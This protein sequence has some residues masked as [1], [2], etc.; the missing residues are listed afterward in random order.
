MN[1]SAPGHPNYQLLFSLFVYEKEGNALGVL[2]GKQGA[3]HQP[4]GYYTQQADPVAQGYPPSLKAIPPT[5]L[6][7]KAT[8]ETAVGSP[9]TIF[10]SHA[11]EAPLNSH[12]THLS[13]SHLTSYEIL[14]LYNSLSHF[15]NLNPATLLPS[16]TDKK[17]HNHLTLTDRLLT[18][19]PMTYKKVES[20]AGISWFTHGSY[21]RKILH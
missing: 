9:V 15:N 18:P 10:M 17:P 5:A 11:V 4:T 1:T 2:T 20:N 3:Y 7:A 21:L 16:V 19:T 14:S 13:A 12:H 6:L 8:K